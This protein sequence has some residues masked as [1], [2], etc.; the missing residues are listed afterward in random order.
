MNGN[1]RSD[2]VMRR[3]GP[4]GSPGAGRTPA[5]KT[6]GAGAREPGSSKTH[7]WGLIAGES[8]ATLFPW[9]Q[10]GKLEPVGFINL[11]KAVK[12]L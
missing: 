9:R 11:S 1:A 8:I 4:R 10:C 5:G 7:A 6:R 12:N 2:F 3:T